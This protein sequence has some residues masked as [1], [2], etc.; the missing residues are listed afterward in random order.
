[1]RPD[2]YVCTSVSRLTLAIGRIGNKVVV[3]GMRNN[4]SGIL[5]VEM[6]DEEPF[7]VNLW[8]PN[9]T[10]SEYFEYDVGNGSH[11]MVLSLIETPADIASSEGNLLE[12]V[13]HLTSI[14]YVLLRNGN[15]HTR[16]Y[17]NRL[18]QILD[19]RRR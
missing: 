11:T 13:L 17:A 8:T 18:F 4:A 1:M 16:E 6:D 15:R 2:P 3:N 10:C 7:T 9:V 5:Q 19:A 12:P 14:T